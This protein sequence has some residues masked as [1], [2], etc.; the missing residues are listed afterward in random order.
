MK[1]YK[2]TLVLVLIL[3]FICQNMQAQNEYRFTEDFVLSW[4]QFRATPD[5]NSH[6]TAAIAT[7][8]GY[9]ITKDGFNFIIETGALFNP[10]S[11]W[12]RTFSNYAL[13]HEYYHFRIA[14]IA[15][16]MMMK[17]LKEFDLAEYKLDIEW[18]VEDRVFMY[19]GFNSNLQDQ[20]DDETNHGSNRI[21]QSEWESK[22]DNQL[23]ELKQFQYR[24]I[25]IYFDNQDKYISRKFTNCL[26]IPK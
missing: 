2:S 5:S 7:T 4:D 22:I 23:L 18:W 8:L 26:P 25:I 16:R 10:D 19:G 17:E 11:S 3:L 20:Y 24:Y 21:Q 13:R 1:V 14:E 12:T 6:W 15:R 9:S